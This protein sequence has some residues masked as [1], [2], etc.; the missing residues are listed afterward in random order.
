MWEEWSSPGSVLIWISSAAP[1]TSFTFWPPLNFPLAFLTGCDALWEQT[2]LGAHSAPESNTQSIFCCL[3]TF[4]YRLIWNHFIFILG[5]NYSWANLNQFWMFI[6]IASRSMSP[7]YYTFY[8]RTQN[9]TE[10]KQV[11]FG[12]L[13]KLKLKIA[14][15]RNFTVMHSHTDSS[16]QIN[17]VV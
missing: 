11:I 8:V 9:V 12:Y 7:A 13:Q 6:F 16:N 15:K 2:W 3:L 10:Y 14:L 17:E 5:F 4:Y 1:L